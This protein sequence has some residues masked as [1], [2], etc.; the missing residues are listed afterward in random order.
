MPAAAPAA[1]AFCAEVR[2]DGVV[3]AARGVLRDPATGHRWSLPPVAR[4]DGHTQTWCW[5]NLPAGQAPA[6]LQ[7]E[8][9]EQNGLFRY[10]P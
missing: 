5:T 7:V 10:Y 6:G 1:G 4:L 8:I 9:W 3:L 2:N